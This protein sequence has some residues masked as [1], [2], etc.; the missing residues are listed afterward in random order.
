MIEVMSATKKN[1]TFAV[2]GDPKCFDTELFI[3]IYID[4]T[5]PIKRASIVYNDVCNF[6]S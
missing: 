2:I 3:G 1:V 4:I 6:V 5:T